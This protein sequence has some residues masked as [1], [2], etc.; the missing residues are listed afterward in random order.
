MRWL[1]K[2][3]LMCLSVVVVI[4]GFV[5]NTSRKLREM[6]RFHTGFRPRPDDIF[7][8][9]FPKSGTTWMQM[10]LVQLLS[11]GDA[12][13]DH[14][15]QKSPYLEELIRHENF[16]YMEK[17]PSPRM[18]KTHLPY[19]ELR[20]SKDSRII[21]VTRDA[22]DTFV[23]CYHHYEMLRRFRS[24]FD[25][26]MKGMVS[27]RG[28][29][30]SWFGYMRSWMP[31]RNDANVLWIRY[32]DLSADLEG[33]VRR[34]AAFLKVSVPE[35][36]MADLLRKCSFE[37]MKQH[38]HKFDF[39]MGLYEENPGTFIRQ[40][41]TKSRQP[42]REEHVAELEANLSKLRGELKLKETETF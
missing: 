32:E 28:F 23:S 4:S 16:G 31:H 11:S 6:I 26:F 24:P 36:R 10:I 14:I 37:Y 2:P 27:G 7:I 39:R 13:F 8:A 30:G 34:I 33:Q 3:F 12:E 35:E 21:F 42:I 29:F 15:L 22:R 40:G 9:T 1:T 5:L 20:P 41:G 19:K 38:N 25:R 17:M 18:F